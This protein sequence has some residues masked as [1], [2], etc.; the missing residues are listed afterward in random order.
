MTEQIHFNRLVSVE[1]VSSLLKN[2]VSS[3]ARTV[4]TEPSS[5]MNMFCY[6]FSMRTMIML[7]GMRECVDRYINEIKLYVPQ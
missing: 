1:S 6:W 5:F 2:K 7:I 3:K 4:S